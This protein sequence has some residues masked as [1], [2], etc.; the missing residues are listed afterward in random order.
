MA[1]TS[2]NLI[3]TVK[4]VQRDVSNAVD[5]CGNENPDMKNLMTQRF[6]AWNDAVNPVLEEASGHLDNMVI[7]QDYADP[8]D[9]RAIFTSADRAR[10]HTNARI[11]KIP[12][13]TKEACEFL[14]SKMDETQAS[15]VALLR[16]TLI[17]VPQ[18]FEKTG[19]GNSVTGDITGNYKPSDL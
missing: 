13:T 6:S 3:E 14:L 7:V 8:K 9:L 12:V 10:E 16:S 4:I 19:G 17:S 2:Y 1:Y 5:G 11:D 15:M 18:V